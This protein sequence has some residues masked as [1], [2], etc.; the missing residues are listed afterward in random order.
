MT[1]LT[2]P[3]FQVDAFTQRQFSGNPAAVCPLETWLPD[4]LMQRIA[5][6]NN[7]S[8]TAFFVKNGDHY[9]IRWFSPACEIAL[10]GHATLAS[11][12]VLTR[13]LQPGLEQIRFQSQSGPLA[14]AVEGERL[15]L[16][17]PAY[18]LESCTQEQWP[19]SSV[20]G[21]EYFYGRGDGSGAY[22]AVLQDIEAVKSFSPNF[23]D[24]ERTRSDL[25]VTAKG[26]SVDFVSRL[27]APWAGIPEDPVTGSAHCLL[28]PFWA[29][30][31]GKN[32]LS[33]R[34]ESQRGGELF[35]EHR[36]NRVNI[37]GHAVLVI[38]GEIQIH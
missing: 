8:E 18:A 7:L 11:A 27:F 15:V 12:F 25:I 9:D 5:T 10:C 20:K 28:V 13:Y 26:R 22:V 29:A 14:V 17:F 23:A 38:K 19:F 34:Q 6:E 31:L 37:A 3:F 21:E 24:L 2:L 1:K 30:R 33:A 4:E 16:D 36:G 35:C 32:K